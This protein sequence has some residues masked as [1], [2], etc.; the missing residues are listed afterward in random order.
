M[1]EVFLLAFAL[2]MDAFAVSIG[3]GV[4]NREFSKILAL[5]VALLFGFFQGLMPLFGYLA[6][7]GLGSII[8]S[9]DHWVAFILLS[10][11]GGKMLYDSFGENTE[12]EIANITNKVLLLLAIATSIDAMAAGFTLNLLA[13]N[14]FVSMIVIGL[15]TYIF[16]Y[17]GVFVGSRGGGYIESKAEKLGGIVLIG[18]GLKILAEHTL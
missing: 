16:S 14:P 8:E 1:L 11:I 9:I 18:I 5:K 2:S 10:A 6:S 13:L 7:L 3:L 17:I 4:K 12:E 15:V